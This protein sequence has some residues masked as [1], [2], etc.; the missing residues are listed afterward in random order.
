M[1]SDILPSVRRRWDKLDK[2]TTGVGALALIYL[3]E[4][5]KPLITALNPTASPVGDAIAFGAVATVLV[6]VYLFREVDLDDLDA[7]VDETIEDAT[8]PPDETK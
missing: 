6:V 4:A 2:K 5:T 8:D 1:S 7:A 3:Q